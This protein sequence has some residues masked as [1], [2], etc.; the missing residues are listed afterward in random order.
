MN[1]LLRLPWSGT[2][3]GERVFVGRPRRA[4]VG[5]AAVPP[6]A[7]AMAAAREVRSVPVRAVP[8]R[9]R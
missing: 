5:G 2:P 7:A 1:L 8:R 3:G 4:G 9:A 6:A